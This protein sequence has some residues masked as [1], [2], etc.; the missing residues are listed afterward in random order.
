MEKLIDLRVRVTEEQKTY[1]TE[2]SWKNR[3]SLKDYVQQLI[4]A[5]MEKHPD[6]RKDLDELNNEKEKGKSVDELKEDLKKHTGEFDD[7]H[8]K[9]MKG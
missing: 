6:W 2:M 5:D 9:I 8:N 7:L 1:L 4:D 3:T